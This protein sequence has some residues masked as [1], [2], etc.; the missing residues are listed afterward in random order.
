VHPFADAIQL[1]HKDC[2]KQHAV[3]RVIIFDLLN[4]RT[5]CAIFLHNWTQCIDG[6]NLLLQR[7]VRKGDDAKKLAILSFFVVTERTHLN[8]AHAP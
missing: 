2:K 8:A 5:I 6:F 3:N 4:T 7:Y 1:A